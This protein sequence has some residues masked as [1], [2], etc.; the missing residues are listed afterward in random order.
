[1]K[2]DGKT[3]EP[4]DFSKKPLVVQCMTREFFGGGFFFFSFHNYDMNISID[5]KS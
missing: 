5:P 4:A 2:L 3:E 1:M